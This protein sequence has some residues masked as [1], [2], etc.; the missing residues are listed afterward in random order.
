MGKEMTTV[1][2][3]IYQADMPIAQSHMFLQA[4]PLVNLTLVS[5]RFSGLVFT[6]IYSNQ[7]CNICLMGCW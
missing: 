5:V 7:K 6:S 3:R 2:M 4:E 1:R